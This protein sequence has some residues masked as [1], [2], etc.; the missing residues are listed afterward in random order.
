MPLPEP[1]NGL[2]IRYSFLWP[3][4][5]EHGQE[6]E[7]DRPAVIVA[8]TKPKADGTRRVVVLPVTHSE[9]DD[10]VA[11][12]EIPQAVKKHLGLDS[13]RSWVRF[14]YANRFEWPGH[15]IVQMSPGKFDYGHLPPNFY[16]NMIER[17][18]EYGKSKRRVRMADRDTSQM[19]L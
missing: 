19:T 11:A 5:G 9:P 4:Q 17:F 13:E 15:D 10:P 7:K 6:V 8:G 2:V 16:Q 12:M 14:D 18:Q 1:K 3:D